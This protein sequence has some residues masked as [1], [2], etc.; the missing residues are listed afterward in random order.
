MIALAALSLGMLHL[1]MLELGCRDPDRPGKDPQ[2]SDPVTDT[3]FDTG[4]DTGDSGGA[5]PLGARPD[6]LP[7]VVII[8]AGPAGLAAAMDLPGS[9]IV[10]AQ[11]EPGGRLRWAGGLLL[12]AGTQTQADAGI[13]DDPANAAAE[14]EGLTGSPPT[15]DTLAF[16]DASAAVHDRLAGIGVSWSIEQ[17]P[18]AWWGTPR[19]H[20]PD[21]G[22]PAVIDALAA[23]LPPS[24]EVIY[25]TP[26]SGLLLRTSPGRPPRVVGVR[27]VHGDIAARAV[28][29]ATGGFVGR[30]DWMEVASD[31]PEGS[32]VGGIEGGADGYALDVADAHALSTDRLSDI[33]WYRRSIAAPGGDGHPIPLDTRV[34]IFW[35]LVDGSGAR[36]VNELQV[37][38]VRTHGVLMDAGDG[39]AIANLDLVTAALPPG[40]LELA[41]ASPDLFRCG[42][43]LAELAAA[44]GV[45]ADGLAATLVDVEQYRHGVPDPFGR[46]GESFPALSGT[47]CMFRPGY[48]AAK[49]FG[50]LV[51]DADGRVPGVTGLWAIGE[52]AGMA[53]PGLGGERG[54][55]GSSGAI[56]WGA[57]RTAAALRAGLEGGD[58]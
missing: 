29:I 34:G 41:E 16:L 58:E 50:G 4:F 5:I 2:D 11:A 35:I 20:K 54:F 47:L 30:A 21:G 7:P 9:V 32:W 31:F 37:G 49:N 45:D 23:A 46:S 1:G 55:D 10:E 38:S 25:E 14:W 8:G 48:E 42:A 43:D 53:A 26:S 12:A 22:G 6:R 27:T 52:A 51:V 40:M 36:V 44:F 33:G 19:L 28:I 56:F 15:A 3:G 24:V 18:G 57:W 17:S 39:W 13:S